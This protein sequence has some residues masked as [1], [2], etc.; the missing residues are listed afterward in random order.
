MQTTNLSKLAFRT[1]F[2]PDQCICTA[3]LRLEHY[4]TVIFH[5]DFPNAKLNNS[6]FRCCFVPYEMPYLVPETM[7]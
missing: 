4:S 5:F 7:I 6:G 1:A 3:Q 2:E